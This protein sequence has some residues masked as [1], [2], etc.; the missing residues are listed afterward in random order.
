MRGLQSPPI[1]IGHSFGGL[2][3]QILLDRGLGAAGV[4]IS[5]APPKGIWLLPLSTL[6]TAFPALKNP[7]NRNRAVP[8]THDQFRYRF[9]NTLNLDES[10]EVYDRYYI[11]G[12]GRVL[13]EAALAN[14][15]PHAP[16]EIDYRNENRAPLLF[17]AGGKDHISPPSLVRANCRKYRATTT[18]TEYKE[19]PRRSH[20][21]AGEP[22]WEAIA[23]EAVEWAV[24]NS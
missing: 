24:R 22:G 9:T 5:S 21:T 8:L 12:T 10:V 1:I 4:A 18:V 14:L 11:P 19:H 15:T 7:A 6:R 23:D 17:M 13:F 2:I 20:W 16:T 3:T